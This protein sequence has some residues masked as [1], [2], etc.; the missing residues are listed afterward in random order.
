MDHIADMITRIK[1]ATDVRKE[2]VV[3][4]Y[5]QL[6]FDIATVLEKEGFL[7]SVSKK[8]KKITKFI[9]VEL[10]Y[11]AEGQP[12]INGVERISKS[13]KRIYQKAKDIFPVKYGTGLLVLTTPK[14]ILTGAQARKEKVGGE[15]LFK[16]W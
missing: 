8:G 15:A 1:N 14:G 5:S 13:S 11:D 10:A 2:S 3:F 7:K 12:K 6:K 16:V 4:P 9:E